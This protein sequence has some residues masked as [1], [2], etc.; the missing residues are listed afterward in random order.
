MKKNTLIALIVLAFGFNN[1]FSQE[2]FKI[3]FYNFLH[4]PLEKT[5]NT[6]LQIETTQTLLSTLE[7]EKPKDFIKI[8]G[9]NFV[10]DVLTLNIKQSN[11]TIKKLHIYNILEQLVMPIPLN[12]ESNLYID[13]SDL[14]S[15][16]YYI[17]T[18]SMN[19]KPLKFIKIH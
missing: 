13:M 8:V 6:Q 14:R 5:V 18:P 1:L 4:F 9:T 2:V 12:E 17:A 19:V 7:T 10:Q 16:I 3:M 15:G 11:V